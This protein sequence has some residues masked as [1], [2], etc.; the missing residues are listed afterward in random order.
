MP[1]SNLLRSAADTCRYCHQ[2]AGIL[3]RGHPECQRTHQAGW[4]E[5]FE[6]AALAAKSHS[7]GEKTLRI[8]LAEIAR[9]SY[10]DGAT[11]NQILEEG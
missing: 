7:F 4:Q 5:M 9:R 11:V 2:R 8:S 1:L 10:G 6:F 3:Q